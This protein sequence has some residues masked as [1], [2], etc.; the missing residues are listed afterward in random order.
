[1]HWVL[2]QDGAGKGE[3]QAVA[4]LGL[5][6]TPRKTLGIF[7]AGPS[8]PRALGS[9]HLLRTMAQTLVLLVLIRNICGLPPW[10]SFYSCPQPP[11]PP[12]AAAGSACRVE[13]EKDPK[14]TS[15]V[16][17]GRKGE[18]GEG[19]VQGTPPP[20]QN[21]EMRHSGTSILEDRGK[22]RGKKHVASGCNGK[23]GARHHSTTEIKT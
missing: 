21:L 10:G 9:S 19:G 16:G 20:P 12:Q 17:K 18:K 7:P 5:E 13:L 11:H 22:G 23:K 6:G 2:W 4:F 8:T 14:R 15:Q 1:M 3:R